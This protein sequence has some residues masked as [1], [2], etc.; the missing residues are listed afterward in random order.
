MNVIFDRTLELRLVQK[1]N[2]CVFSYE[3]LVSD[4]QVLRVDIPYI[5][6]IK[7]GRPYQVSVMTNVSS[8]SVVSSEKEYWAQGHIISFKSGHMIVSFHGLI[9]KFLIED[10][11]ICKHIK[12]AMYSDGFVHIRIR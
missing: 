5:Y 2:R 1:Y 12:H 9:G 10:V 3:G 6:K 8:D 11:K 4:E 7:E